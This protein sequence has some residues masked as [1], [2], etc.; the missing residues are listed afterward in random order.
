MRLPRTTLTVITA[1]PP[2]DIILAA[3][4]SAAL[5]ARTITVITTTGDDDPKTRKPPG[6]APGGFFIRASLV[7]SRSELTRSP[8]PIVAPAGAEACEC[9]A[10]RSEE[11]RVGKE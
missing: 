6:L 5:L 2:M 10:S 11:R 4:S 8:R 1:I 7:P 9:P 3:F